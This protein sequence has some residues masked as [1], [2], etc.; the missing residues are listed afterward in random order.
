MAMGEEYH[1]IKYHYEEY[2][3]V[4]YHYVI[5]KSIPFYLD[6]RFELYLFPVSGVRIKLLYFLLK[7]TKNQILYFFK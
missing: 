5:A 7:L 6:K 1:I 3:I 2:Q 4:K